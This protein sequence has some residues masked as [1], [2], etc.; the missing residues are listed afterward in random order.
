MGNRIVQGTESQPFDLFVIDGG[1]NGAGVARDAAGRGPSVGLAEQ[2]DL[3]G[4]RSSASTKLFHGV[5]PYLEYF[6]FR[7][8]REALRE[9][10]TLLTSMPHIFRR[11]RT[12]GRQA[13]HCQE[14]IFRS[15]KL[16]HLSDLLK[17]NIRSWVRC[18]QVVW[19]YGLAAWRILEGAKSPQDLWD[20]FGATLTEAEVRWHLTHEFAQT[21]EDVIW[22]RTKLGL[23]LSSSEI[24]A[25]DEWIANN[26]GRTAA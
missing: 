2:G 8:V 6:E 16:E 24:Q 9:R 17:K 13:P 14:E 18:G 10:E 19:T 11:I 1:V 23:R 7:L 4:A 12:L 26:E 22:L 3:G 5:L 25:L 15:S 21:V 20:D